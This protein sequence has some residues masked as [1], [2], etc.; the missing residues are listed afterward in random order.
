M[1]LA[2]LWDICIKFMWNEE[3]I[4]SLDQFLNLIRLKRFWIALAALD[5]QPLRLKSELGILHIP[6]VASK[7]L[8]FLKRNLKRKTPN[9]SLSFKL[10]RTF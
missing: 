10:A 4:L 5:F 3:Y 9:S 6:M 8:I 1:T 2:E 7:C